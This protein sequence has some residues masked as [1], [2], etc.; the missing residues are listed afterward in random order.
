[1]ERLLSFL[2]LIVCLNSLAYADPG[3]V[4]FA[5]T[6]HVMMGNEV[7]LRFSPAQTGQK[8]APLHLP[9]GLALTYGELLT[10]PDFYSAPAKPI[11]F[12]TTPEERKKLF[13]EAY[14]SLASN[15]AAVK[16]AE[17]LLSLIYQ[18][19]EAV[20]AGMQQGLSPEE[21]YKRIGFE[22][23]RQYNCVTGGGCERDNWWMISGRYLDVV[24]ANY[25]HFGESA[26]IAYETGHTL[27]LEM[28]LSAHETW[29]ASRLE[30]AYAINAFACHFLSDRFSAGHMRT[31]R[32][33]LAFETIPAD[34]GTILS[35]YMHEEENEAGLHVHNAKGD[36]WIAYGDK[37]W[38]NPKIEVHKLIL[39]QALQISAD[40]IFTTYYQGVLPLASKVNELVPE[41]DEVN[42]QNQQDISPLFYWDSNAKKLKRRADITNRYDR[43]WTDDWW[44]WTTL[45][46]LRNA[47]GLSEQSKAIL[48]EPD[49]KDKA[50][51]NGML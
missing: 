23:D 33:K 37:S 4:Y 36:H 34:F 43:H 13:L 2:F 25:D 22:F 24:K 28:A 26:M 20:F 50:K 14:N 6:E 9:N 49:Y 35:G 11:T 7:N 18:E 17:S 1:M 44:G 47:T 29:D 48:N 38:F 3:L 41:P 31:P 16:E 40:E 12:G 30:T 15:P 32:T 21:A 27:A 8:A 46:A 19:Q 10:L 51:E 5:S 45:I 39:K 42:N